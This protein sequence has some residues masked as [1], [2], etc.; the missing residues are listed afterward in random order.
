[1]PP[2]PSAPAFGHWKPDVWAL[3]CCLYA[4]RNAL[5]SS[6]PCCPPSKGVIELLESMSS[7]RAVPALAFVF[8]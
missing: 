5:P 8:P 7:L 1:M 3:V 2:W 6:P 4:V